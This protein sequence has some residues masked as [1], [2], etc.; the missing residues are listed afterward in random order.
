LHVL[1]KPDS[2]Y[3]GLSF[4]ERFTHICEREGKPSEKHQETG[5][6]SYEK[7]EQTDDPQLLAGTPAM[8]QDGLGHEN[9]SCEQCHLAYDR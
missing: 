9:G 5:P 8:Q 4:R 1:V 7:H 6:K 2:L 3:K